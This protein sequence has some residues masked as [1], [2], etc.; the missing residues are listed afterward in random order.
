MILW[1]WGIRLKI[2][3]PRPESEPKGIIIESSFSV[4]GYKCSEMGLHLLCR[5]IWIFNLPHVIVY[6]LCMVDASLRNIWC[7]NGTF[8]L[9]YKCTMPWIKS[10]NKCLYSVEVPWKIKIVLIEQCGRC[11]TEWSLT[12]CWYNSNLKV[13]NEKCG[14]NLKL[15]LVYKHLKK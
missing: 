8:S 6:I 13:W 12:K 1:Y 4:V 3:N 14:Y 10:L 11:I 15:W 9:S 7:P 2:W 5:M